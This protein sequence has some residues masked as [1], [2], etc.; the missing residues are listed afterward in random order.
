MK[1]KTKF[2]RQKPLKNIARKMGCLLIALSI[3][4]SMFP[5]ESNAAELAAA[6]GSET[7]N[8]GIA[9]DTHIS[10]ADSSSGKVMETLLQNCLKGFYKATSNNLDA[11]A[12]AGDL[13]DNGYV[14]ELQTFRSIIDSELGSTTRFTA[15]MGNHEFYKQGSGVNVDLNPGMKEEMQ[16]D[17][18][19]NVKVPI[20]DDISVEGVHILS[21]S[22]DNELDSYTARES[23]LKQKI[24]AAAAEDPT[25]PII[26]IAHKPVR[27]TVMSSGTAPDGSY[28]TLAAD[29]SDEFLEFMKQY[30]Q[31][32][33]FS[34]HA[35]D[36]LSN[37][38]NIYQEDFTS[39]QAGVVSA[40]SASTGLL[41]SIDSDKVVT[42]NRINFS[43]NTY[44]EPA[45]TID[46]P[47]V[48]QNK[49]NFQYRKVNTIKNINLTV[50]TDASELYANWYNTTYHTGKVQFGKKSN[51]V[52]GVL[53][54]YD[55]VTAFSSDEAV[56]S[57]E[58][59]PYYY[60]HALIENL[61]AGTEYVYR[62]GNDKGWSEYYTFTTPSLSDDLSFLFAAD[63]QVG[64]DGEN[65]D[66]SGW[67]RTMDNAMAKFPD[68]QFLLSVGDQVE[69]A[70]SSS[71]YD[72][73]FSPSQL[74]SL[75]ISTIVGNHDVNSKLYSQHF[76]YSNVA[77]N[78]STKSTGEYSGDYWFVRNNT[79]FMMLNSNVK[80]T[81][82]HVNFMQQAILD[83]GDSIKWKVVMFHHSIFST[84]G[85]AGD[86]EII[87]RRAALAPVLS[88]LQIDLALMGHDHVYCRTYM[89][90]GTTPVTANGVESSVTNP[91]PGLVLGVTGNSASGSKYYDMEFEDA[92]Y[93]AV[94]YQ[95][96]ETS[97]SHVDITD[98]TLIIS[99]Y[100]SDDMEETD[101]FT[102]NKTQANPEDTLK[103]YLFVPTENTVTLNTD[104]DKLK[105]VSAID[106]ADGN[107]TDKIIVTGEV[108]S[109]V[110]GEYILTYSITDQAGN[111]S[112]AT[113][114]IVVK[115]E[116]I[117]TG[118]LFF[119]ID[120]KSGKLKNEE[121]SDVSYSAY[122]DTGG[123]VFEKDKELNQ[124]VLCGPESGN[125]V[126]NGLNLKSLKNQY[127][128]ETYIK[129]PKELSPSSPGNLT[130]YDIFQ[131]DGQN[132]N[133]VGW[134][135]NTYFGSGRCSLGDADVSVTKNLPVDQWIHVLCT[136]KEGE[137]KLYVN[138]SEFASN[139]YTSL[140]IAS[141]NDNELVLGGT[142]SSRSGLIK[143]ASFRIYG[144]FTTS[145]MAGEMYQEMQDSFQADY[146]AVDAAIAK[147]PSDLSAYTD[148]SVNVLQAAVD[149]VIRGKAIKEQNLVDGYAA[150]IESAIQGLKFKG[151]AD[152][153]AVNAAIAKIPSDLSL[154]T[155]ASVKTLNDAKNA[156]EPGK[157]TSEQ[158]IVDGYATAIEN[159]ISALVYRQA[160]Y[161]K[162][163]A[164][165]AKIPADLS[166]YT[167]NS[168]QALNTVKNA[169]VAGKDSSEQ[170]LVDG[171]AAAIENAIKG[172]KIKL[173]F[174]IDIKNGKLE[175][176]IGS[177]VSD[178]AYLLTG[179]APEDKYTFEKDDELN[180]TVLCGPE[181]ENLIINNLNLKSLGNQ[182]TIETYIKIPGDLSPS[183][184][185]KM[186]AYD[187]FQFD[188]QNINLVGLPGETYFG[189]GRYK[190]GDA[191]VSTNKV[192]PRDQWIH[193]LCT[194]KEGG[195]T[196]YLNGEKFAS[197]AYKGLN[198][199]SSGA[200]ELVL[201]GTTDSRSGLIKFASFRIYK[202]FVDD[203]MASTMYTNMKNTFLL[204]DY[205]GVD[206]AIAKIPADLSVYTDETVSALNDAVNAVVRGKK[207]VEQNLVDG[208]A[209][210]IENATKALV[211]KSAADKTIDIAQIVG[212]AVPVT[213]AAPTSEIGDTSEYTATIS[214]SPADVTFSADTEYT[215]TITITPKAGYT[216]SGVTKDFFTV[217]GTK[218]VKN[219]A[220]SGVITVVYPKTE[221]E[222][223]K[224]ILVGSQNGIITSGT[225][226]SA[227]FAA[228]LTNIKGD[229]TVTVKWC[230]TD[231]ESK[232]EPKGIHAI[233]T[234]VE[235]NSSMI[236][237]T[238]DESAVAGTYYFKVSSDGVNSA[239][240][241]LTITEQSV[242]N[243]ESHGSKGSTAKTEKTYQA[244]ASGTGMDKINQPISVDA[245]TG[246]AAV[247]L[248]SQQGNVFT[249]GGTVVITVPSIP[250]INNYSIGI[251]ASSLTGSEQ[252]GLLTFST[253]SGS[254]TIPDNMLRNLSG[255][256]EKKVEIAIGAGDKSHLA[257]E[258]RTAIGDRPLV[259]I[260]L[261]AG[262]V[263]TEWN[264]PDA[265]VTVSIP[266]TPTASEL[267]NPESIVVWYID[268]S[269]KA[270][271]VPNGH[272]DAAT[273]TVTFTT[274]HFSDYA[275][276][277]N[278]TDFK[279]VAA[280]KW[281]G[282]AVSFVAAR[283]I[284]SGTGN[285]SYS[286]NAKLTR[287][288]FLVML[289]KAYGI[290]PEASI[291]DNFSD[292]G[293][294]YYTEYLAEAKKS[295][296]SEGI[297]NNLFAPNKQ[298]TRQEMFTM[299]YNALNVMGEL[300]E[301]NTG[302]QVNKFS[303][304]DQIDSW[305]KNAMELLVETGT[306]KGKD[307]KLSPTGTTTRAE[308]AQVL[309]N[310]L[311]K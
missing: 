188:D 121:N 268:G 231:G 97:I 71:Q 164:A 227:T 308:M 196:L 298:I 72:G 167:S 249:G 78:T 157:G 82:A 81:Q 182:Y 175:N 49:D 59:S 19:T 60:N 21:V 237:V 292:A 232:S 168:V 300:P 212:V 275:V 289:M 63:P 220:D 263:Q 266:Y 226:G 287:G 93:A 252:K 116:T 136:A 271:A 118:S 154:Y 56:D 293:N 198:I 211:E 11:V 261:K 215:A 67:E 133:L 146:T 29:W 96:Y 16:G 264:N 108:D 123:Y 250:G 185:G 105:D 296:I 88:N 100:N 274:T 46:I 240:I 190:K 68:S 163:N 166:I 147:I 51:L 223:T 91:D 128:I 280:D 130:A 37:A 101:R 9:T 23:F 79:L 127:T 208:Y 241:T 286:P 150:A 90:N 270:V 36:D 177:D 255:I 305:A 1:M 15:V 143:Y 33:Y 299:M 120:I 132:I 179:S 210:E 119:G 213:G 272:Y 40:V 112:T 224:F 30:P 161:T 39:V 269:G 285:G 99:T 158:E 273:R 203:E 134:T 12:I 48:I 195:Q 217:E 178:S 5:I 137:Q 259:Q 282:K 86:K 229:F 256:N 106:N 169:V 295:G 233:G 165:I 66:L 18:T 70:S 75:P 65:F 26:I 53:S 54:S 192:L 277:F 102:I 202:E 214:W 125:L 73:F 174:G 74:T 307:G 205:A 7:I 153:T 186:T 303:D 145:K 189:A 104:F 222:P 13:T 85:H 194:A 47:K 8:I 278:V 10:R 94:T 234:D 221:P 44:I 228:I 4:T 230:D 243:S 257:D 267:K 57:S 251:P 87:E 144:S 45:W 141:T 2:D 162:V 148:D 184:P 238:A 95:N 244:E 135:G 107:I 115:K 219:E 279:D 76:A 253:E 201:G 138:G 32:I 159:A 149:G 77:S 294:T 170:E 207:A 310:L 290:T 284:T 52:D 83:A 155:E 109:S 180:Q 35:H 283:G 152:Y 113:R 262:G 139:Y 114:A 311:S 55:E 254:L 69:L 31:I 110:E 176:E 172:L 126:I 306:I 209:A 225:A 260:T 131:F 22:P 197:A 50:G 276:G 297:G 304:A 98:T 14:D 84:A 89:M 288:E 61:D 183:S 3:L 258:V 235:A 64:S 247:D 193:V 142:Y 92:N 20:E 173:H 239:A 122:K 117:G 111:T 236:T 191:D 248:G 58:A 160:D 156:V 27:Y 80:D 281:Y 301:G 24:A 309:Y 204:A 206:E 246:S 302:S 25:N 43:A 103:P 218:S 242:I 265:P 6:A 62:V 171:Y 245:K 181:K 187:V 28:A 200:D 151:D 38:N 124:T 291:S 216:L 34:G 41:L 129:I 17:F 140:N 199:A 42:I